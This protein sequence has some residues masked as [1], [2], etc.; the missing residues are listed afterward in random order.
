MEEFKCDTRGSLVCRCA[1]SNV[2]SGIRETCVCLYEE[3]EDEV[4]VEK[5]ENKFE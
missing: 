2:I 5:E 3:A 4:R 1:V